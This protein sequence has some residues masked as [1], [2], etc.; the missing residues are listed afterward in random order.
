VSDHPF[1]FSFNPRDFCS[2]GKVEAM[3]TLEV[4]AYT[5][6][7]CKAWFED[8][9]GTVPDDDQVLARWAR[10]DADG[11]A[12]AKPS[13]L[14]AFYMGEDGRWHQKRM[15]KEYARLQEFKNERSASGK[16]GAQS[17]WAHRENGS[18]ISSAMAEHVANDSNPRSKIQ[19]KQQPRAHTRAR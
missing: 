4:G 10:L 16:R 19:K 1:A 3:S 11:W 9:A 12:R 14:A 6:L 17:C 18:A 7:L 13:V 5:L 8:P 15:K 2:D